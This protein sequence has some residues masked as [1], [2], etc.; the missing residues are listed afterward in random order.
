MDGVS[1]AASVLALIEIS[2]KVVSVCADY[3]SNVQNAKNDID[4]VRLEIEAFLDVLRSLHK[5]AQNPKNADIFASKSLSD[6]IEQC[7]L[8]LQK[9]Q[10]KLDLGKGRKT[11]SRL[12]IRA[13]KWPFESKDIQQVMGALERYKSTFSLNLS[14]NQ[15]YV[16]CSNLIILAEFLPTGLSLIRQSWTVVSQNFLALMALIM[17]HKS[18]SMNLYVFVTHGLIFCV[19]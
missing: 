6:S 19:R 4:R 3:Y 10:S 7:R 12:G 11:M 16:S 14:V 15:T 18:Y 17:I 2:L 9:L 8:D 1:A 13:L 5:L